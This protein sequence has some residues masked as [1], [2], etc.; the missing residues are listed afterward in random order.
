MDHLS[1]PRMIMAA[2][3]QALQERDTHYPRPEPHPK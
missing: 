2:D 1:N 3:L